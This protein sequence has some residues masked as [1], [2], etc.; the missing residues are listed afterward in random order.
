MPSD[1]VFHTLQE[2]WPSDIPIARRLF[3][4]DEIDSTNT[5]ALENG[6]S[7][8]VIL[9]DSQSAGRGRRGR[10]WFSTPGKGLWFTVVMGEPFEGLVMA[11]ALAVRDAIAPRHEVAIKWPNDILG[12]GKKCCG[13]LIESQGDRTALGIGVNVHHVA[14]D[15]PEELREKAGSLA[16]IF[17]GTWSREVLLL[18]ILRHLDQKV[19]LIQQGHFEAVRKEWA[20]ACNLIGRRISIN[21]ESG[22]VE[23]IDHR[24]A[25]QLRTSQGTQTVFSGDITYLNGE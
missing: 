7:G 6:E 1:S 21:N 15:F 5:Y 16:S 9:A 22:V 19:M 23:D 14:E 25:L 3:A 20:Q 13:I 11:A 2:N 18:D 12:S 10:T 4:F 17:G 24:G 8:S